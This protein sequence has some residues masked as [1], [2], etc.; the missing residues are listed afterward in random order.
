M[1]VGEP[2]LAAAAPAGGPARLAEDD[3]WHDVSFLAL[4]VCGFGG[5]VA[6]CGLALQEHG[7]NFPKD[8]KVNSDRD[9]ACWVALLCT[10]AAVSGSLAGIAMWL[11]KR[12]PLH[13][14]YVMV[15]IQVISLCA[16]LY[17][18]GLEHSIPLELFN[19]C[20]PKHIWLSCELTSQ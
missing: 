2:V 8:M 7:I 20:S 11:L 5:F 13:M 1:A 16:C 10:A 4:F 15:S 19:A 18:L 3:T 6:C 14:T 17:I 12:W 9:V